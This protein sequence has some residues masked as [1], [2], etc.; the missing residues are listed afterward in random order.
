TR[1]GFAAAVRGVAV[2]VAC[3]SEGC[4]R[5]GTGGTPFSDGAVADVGS[6]GLAIPLRGTDLGPLLAMTRVLLRYFCCN[7][8]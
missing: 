7:A 5:N 4:A 6:I 1:A 8:I 2:F 3:C